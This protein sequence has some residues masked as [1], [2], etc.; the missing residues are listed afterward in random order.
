VGDASCLQRSIIEGSYFP[1]IKLLDV[2]CWRFLVPMSGEK[3]WNGDGIA[4]AL[5]IKDSI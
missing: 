4:F 2:Y 5:F 1:R 3:P